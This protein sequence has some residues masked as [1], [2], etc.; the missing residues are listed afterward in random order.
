MPHNRRDD[1]PEATVRVGVTIEGL[2][3][4][5]KIGAKIPTSIFEMVRFVAHEVHIRMAVYPPETDANQPGPYPARWYQRQFGRRWARVD[6]SIGGDDSSEQLQKSWREVVVGPLTRE[7]WTDVSYAPYVQS[8]E[9]QTA[10]MRAIGWQTD[11]DVANDVMND[12]RIQGQ[13]N[14]AIDAALEG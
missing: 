6:G 13:I 5:D 2:D 14:R 1:P 10:T 7:V 8:A 9:D 4:L 3:K 11:E 12:T